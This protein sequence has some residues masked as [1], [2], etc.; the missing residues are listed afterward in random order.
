M[1][2]ARHR[3]AIGLMESRTTPGPA[4]LRHHD[5]VL[6]TLRAAGFSIAM[7]AHAYSLLDS[8][9]YGF[10]LQAPSLP[11]DSPDATVVS[12]SCELEDLEGGRFRPRC[13]ERRESAGAMDV[14]RI[15]GVRPSCYGQPGSSWAPQSNTALR[16]MGI[17]VYLDE[18]SQVGHLHSLGCGFRSESSSRE[19]DALALARKRGAMVGRRVDSWPGN[20]PIH[21]VRCDRA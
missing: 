3:W 5:T 12:R 21:L 4:T 17:S 1:G 20:R 10:A 14:Q 6:G 15:F 19:S 9:I 11:F 8:Y 16:H 7:A 13:G 2:A 18:G